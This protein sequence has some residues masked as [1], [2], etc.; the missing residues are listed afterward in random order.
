[1]RAHT[2]GRSHRA[3]GEP[4]GGRLAPAWAAL[5]PLVSGILLLAAYPPYGRHGLAWIALTPLLWAAQGEGAGRRLLLLSF[6]GGSL[7]GAGLFYP[8]LWIREGTAADRIG[9]MTLLCLLTG[10]ILALFAA[11]ARAAGRVFESGRRLTPAAWGGRDVL[12][13][14]VRSFLTGGGRLLLPPLLASVWVCIEYVVRA[15]AAGF[16]SYLG[17][18]QWQAPQVLALASYG[19][20]YGL[21]WFIVAVNGALSVLTSWA[22]QRLQERRTLQGTMRGRGQGGVES[23]S[24]AGNAANLE[25]AGVRWF[26]VALGSAALIA[27]AA[28]GQVG[29]VSRL[30]APG[31]TGPAGPADSGAG[32]SGLA[33]ELWDEAEAASEGERTGGLEGER[34]LRVV[35]VQPYIVPAEYREAGTLEG[36]RALWRRTLELAGQALE[37]AGGGE[38]ETLVV[39]PETVVHYAAWDD[40]AFRRSLAEFA[41]ARNVHWLGGLPRSFDPQRDGPPETP[42]ADLRERNSAYLVDRE[43]TLR[44]IYDK[45]Y[46]IPIAEKQFARGAEVG[47]ARVGRHVIG[48]GICSDIVAPDHALATVRAGATSLHYIASLGHIGPIAR[49]EQAFVVLRAAEHGVYVTQT[50]TTGFTLAADP[51]GRVIARAKADGPDA[52]WVAVGPD[53]SPTPYTR[54]GDWVPLVSAVCVVGGGL[55]GRRSA[56]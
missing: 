52:I 56:G 34:P 54:L 44:W 39:M 35:L 18:T 3:Q 11:S 46:V 16:S 53:R 29:P 45:I 13:R 41:R 20:V 43:G 26:L 9:G 28:G 7:W 14:R 50:A 12:P 40:P 19:G 30:V 31:G 49:L 23:G 24:R 38:A 25:R 22:A 1:M 32:L 15:A 21:S 55:L 48:L 51:R 8:L 27:L 36:Q 6:A 4:A 2:A 42:G 10:T 37:A 5:L 17:V 47:V 33:S